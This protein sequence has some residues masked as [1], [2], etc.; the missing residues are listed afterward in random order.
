MHIIEGYLPI[1]HCAVWTAVSAGPLLWSLKALNLAGMERRQRLLL[2]A[3]TGFLFA[4]TAL[5][6]PSVAGS[7]S[8]PAGTA[9]GT[10][11]LGPAYMPALGFLV[12]LFQA[13]LLAHGGLTT[14]G[15]NLFSLGVAGPVLIWVVW[16]G[17]ATLRLP[18]PAAV[19]AA[20]IAGS[21]GTY[22]VTSLQLAMAY[23][24][25]PDGVLSSFV[26]FAGIF[27]VTQIPVSLLE[28]LLTVFALQAIGDRERK[29]AV[30]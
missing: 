12:L 22:L 18:R 23:P 4:L 5:K 2:A 28:G 19:A 25:G 17:A 14:L 8:H 15:A 29:A 3:S 9:L 21:V 11:L 13:L 26:R 16:N 24:A 30:L 7:T 27:A 1:D 10:I 6:L 20:A